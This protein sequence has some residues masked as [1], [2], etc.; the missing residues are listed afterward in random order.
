[1]CVCVCVCV[2]VCVCRFGKRY[3]LPLL[4][5]S[6]VM[7]ATML[8]MMHQCVRV[9]AEQQGSAVKRRIFGTYVCG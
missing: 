1:M 6:C 9:K 5:Q 7:I 8:V 4:L 3:E 2:F